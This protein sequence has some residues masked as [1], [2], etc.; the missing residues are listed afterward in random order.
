[1]IAAFSRAKALLANRGYG[2]DWF[3]HAL[4]ERGIT[5]CIPSKKKGKVPIPH[6][7]AL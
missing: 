1:M 4:V 3:R 6:D 5:S 2:A 7:T